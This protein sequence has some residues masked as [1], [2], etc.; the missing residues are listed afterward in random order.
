M[1]KI[2][3]S[4]IFIFLFSANLFA[5]QNQ[6]EQAIVDEGKKLY[7]IEMATKYA[8]DALL[9]KYPEQ[10]DNVSDIVSYP[11]KQFTKCVFIS[12]GDN[13]LVIATVLFDSTFNIAAATIDKTERPLTVIEN[14]ISIIKKAALQLVNSSILFATYKNTSLHLIPLITA[15]SRKVFV[16][17]VPD[18]NGVVYFGNDYC[19]QFNTSNKVISKKPLHTYVS[20]VNY[21]N[22]ATLAAQGGI[23][24]MHQ[25]TTGVGDVMTSTDICI[26]ILNEKIAKWTNHIT[27]SD[28]KISVW[29]CETNTLT[30]MSKYA[31]ENYSRNLERKITKK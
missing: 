4:T 3:Y 12:K 28:K 14:N 6:Q 25:H 8:S 24:S 5:Y 10:K 15:D 18:E 21:I 1:K 7:S 19:I 30:V 27:I 9:E 2:V 13:P 29:T 20:P 11:E 23:S 17:T 26:I 22:D 31:F 16:I